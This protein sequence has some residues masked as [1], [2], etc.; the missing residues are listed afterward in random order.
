MPFQNTPEDV[1]TGTY[2]EATVDE[3]RTVEEWITLSVEDPETGERVDKAFGFVLIPAEHVSWPKKQRIVQEVGQSSRKGFDFVEYYS[4]MFDYQVQETSFLPDHTTVKE[5]AT[6]NANK[7][8]LNK[9]EDFVPDPMDMGDEGISESVLEILE[10]YA[11]SEAGS[12]DASV[13]HFRTWL[14]N[15]SGVGEG[16]EGNLDG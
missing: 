6:Q 8:L 11:D 2:S 5:W 3:T 15:Q 14:K 10:E 4:R 9:L 16:V 7:E 1:E 13:E 12:W